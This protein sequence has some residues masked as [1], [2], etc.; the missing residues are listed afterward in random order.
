MSDYDELVLDIREGNA[1]I[2]RLQTRIAEL[3]EALRPFAAVLGHDS[4]GDDDP[5][6]VY[7][8]V[9]RARAALDKE[10]SK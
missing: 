8:A 5:W 7:A 9:R 3:E 10:E 2:R 6:R 1:K 4:L